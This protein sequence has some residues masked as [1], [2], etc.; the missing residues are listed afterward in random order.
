MYPAQPHLVHT[1]RNEFLE[2]FSGLSDDAVAIGETTTAPKD[3]APSVVL[4]RYLTD[5]TE[6]NNLK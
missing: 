4:L 5:G 1:N 3:R 2:S 6:E